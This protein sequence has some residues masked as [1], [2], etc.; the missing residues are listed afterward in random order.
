M[1]ES[2]SVVRVLMHGSTEG[3]NSDASVNCPLQLCGLRNAQADAIWIHYLSCHEMTFMQTTGY[4][5]RAST[6]Y[7]KGRG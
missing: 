6:G 4:V 7:Y 5:R 1:F 2:P 3:A